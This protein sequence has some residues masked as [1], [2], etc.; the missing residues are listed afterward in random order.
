VMLTSTFGERLHAREAGIDIY[1][2][3]PVRRV[4][5]RNAL[6]E[7]LGIQSRRDRAPDETTWGA[8][9][10]P[11][12]LVV[13]DND[14]NQAVAVQML[15]RRG[16]EP[17]VVANGRKALDALEH[18]RYAAVLMD[19]QMPELDGYQA[20]IELRRRER[21]ERTPIIAM[22]AYAMRGD[23]DKCLDC[24]MD[25]YLAK[26]LRPSELDR[27]LRRWAP[28]TTSDPDAGR[29]AVDASEGR[30]PLDPAGVERLRAEFDGTDVL[31]ELVGLF[32]TQIPVL[33]ENLRSAVQA[34]DAE[35]VSAHA[36]KLKGSAVTLAAVQIAELCDELESRASR[37]LLEGAELLVEQIHSSFQRAHTSLLAEVG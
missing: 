30:N 12:I 7:A 8:G 26:P 35:S 22:T 29:S 32:G 20:T 3:K 16:Y 14:V 15:K 17:H 5:L 23:Q 27:I 25:D 4:R 11:A 1:M 9:S 28:R 24:G 37:Q 10:S 2:T 36:H 13:E 21:G 33:V 34:G 31:A 6:A 19:C 18:R